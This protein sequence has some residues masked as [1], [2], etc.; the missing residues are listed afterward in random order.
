MKKDGIGGVGGDGGV[1]GVLAKP[2]LNKLGAKSLTLRHQTA[3]GRTGRG[4]A[5]H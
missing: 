4:R 3:T 5:R 1:E 2:Q